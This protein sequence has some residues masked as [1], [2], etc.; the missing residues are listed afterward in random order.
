VTNTIKS[1]DWPT[2]LGPLSFF[3]SFNFYFPPLNFLSFF[4]SE[5][6]EE[7]IALK[8]GIYHSRQRGRWM[9]GET[10]F[11]YLAKCHEM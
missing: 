7:A 4:F 8:K 9:K 2:P 5:T 11:P 6:L 10:R 1:W 3:F